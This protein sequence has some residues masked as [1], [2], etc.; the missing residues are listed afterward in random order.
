VSPIGSMYQRKVSTNPEK[1]LR[2]LVAKML[3]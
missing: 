1:Y 3:G 2:C